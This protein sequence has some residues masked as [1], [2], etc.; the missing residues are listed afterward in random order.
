MEKS[1]RSCDRKLR[2]VHPMD[3]F[4]QAGVL[5]N[6]TMGEP[7]RPEFEVKIVAADGQPITALNNIPVIP[8][9]RL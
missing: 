8:V 2:S 6:T 3:M 1:S 7:T 4:L 9:C 5:S